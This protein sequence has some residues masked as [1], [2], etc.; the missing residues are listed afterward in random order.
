MSNCEILPVESTQLA[1]DDQLW[2]GLKFEII[3]TLEMSKQNQLVGDDVHYHRGVWWKQLNRFFCVPCSTF[4]PIDPNKS[5]PKWQNCVAGYMHLCPSTDNSNSTYK[6]I[7][8]DE[9]NSYSIQSLGSKDSIRGVR[10]A[11]SKVE[12]RVVTADILLEEG[13]DVYDSWH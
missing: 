7:V 13:G 8:N 10:R 2:A 5:W 3:D 11:L 6:A 9:V 12:V 1:P 4:E